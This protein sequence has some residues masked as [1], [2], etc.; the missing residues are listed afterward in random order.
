MSVYL[1]ILIIIACIGGLW[2]GALW[3]VDSASRIAKKMGLS[4]LVIGLTIVAIATSA[5]EFVVTISAALKGSSE[6]SLG[7][8]VGSNIFNLGIILGIVIIFTTIKTTKL[9]LYRD[10]F[11]LVITALLLIVFF[12]DFRLSQIEGI[13]LFSILVIYIVV[14]FRHKEP[15]EEDVPEGL[16]KWTDIPLLLAGAATVIIS[17]SYFVDAAEEIALHFG[18]SKWFI[19]ITIVASGTSAPELATSIVAIAKGK[20]GISAGNLI[21]SDL[22]NMLGVLGMAGI[23]S[24]LEISQTEYNSLFLMFGALAVLMVMIRTGWKLTRTEGIIL[25]LIALFRWSF[26]ILVNM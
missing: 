6:I 14:L 25:I 4:D 23:L 10:G 2:A 16:F 7:N 18:L 26:D 8:I 13:I 1:N 15:L 22:F 24:P 9:I 20:H 11:L 12:S 5:P 19:G 3:V 21:G 17:G